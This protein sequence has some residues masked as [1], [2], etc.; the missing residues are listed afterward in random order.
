MLSGLTVYVHRLS[1]TV[2]VT[3]W[4]SPSPS[5]GF[6]LP[7][8]DDTVR[9]GISWPDEAFLVDGGSMSR[10][11]TR[12]ID[13]DGGFK[14]SIDGGPMSEFRSIGAVAENRSYGENEDIG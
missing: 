13:V 11:E 4:V 3:Y 8:Q 2:T 5:P 12:S 6:G 1:V 14:R 9:H 7:A 10:A